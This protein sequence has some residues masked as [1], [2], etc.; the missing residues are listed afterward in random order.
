MTVDTQKLR[1]LLAKATPGQLIMATSNSWRRIVT[2]MRSIPVCVPYAQHDGHPDLHFP[3]GGPAGPDATLLLEARNAL[4]ALLDEIDRLRADR[5][6]LK[7]AFEDANETLATIGDY[8]HI[9]STGPM[10]PDALWE[11]RSMAYDAVRLPG[12]ANCPAALQRDNT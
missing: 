11:I 4:P 2:L 5:D 1:E 10:R 9:K 7:Q 12:P 3:N 8:A 6:A